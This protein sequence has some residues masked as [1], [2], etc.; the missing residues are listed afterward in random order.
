MGL[1]MEETKQNL[2]ASGKLKAWISKGYRLEICVEA[3][4][5]V[6]IFLCWITGQLHFDNVVSD[7]T[8][9][10][11]ALSLPVVIVQYITSKK[12]DKQKK[13]DKLEEDKKAFL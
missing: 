6:L 1:S 7:G 3:C 13:A 5:I 10:A 12:E 9:M 11:A 2:S 8:F 4:I